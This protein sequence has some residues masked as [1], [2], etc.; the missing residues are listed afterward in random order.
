MMM[1]RGLMPSDVGDVV[2]GMN[3]FVYVWVLWA[4]MTH[5]YAWPSSSIFF[6]F[7]FVRAQCE[8]FATYAQK[9]KHR[10]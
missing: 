7:F 6:F 3:E 5:L 9:R 8:Q 4:E 1:M 10:V 2:E